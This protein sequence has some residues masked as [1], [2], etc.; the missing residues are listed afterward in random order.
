MR[1][2]GSRL[3]SSLALLAIIVMSMFL[4]Y[5][6]ILLVKV[7]VEALVILQLYICTIIAIRIDRS[8][9]T[10]LMALFVAGGGL[11]FLTQVIWQEF[12][13][14]DQVE[15][16]MPIAAILIGAIIWGLTDRRDINQGRD[17]RKKTI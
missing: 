10:R 16:F 1:T 4:R 6:G 2:P 14:A 9:P 5:G 12:K 17:R 15:V 13:N 11:I 8:D 3:D 7:V